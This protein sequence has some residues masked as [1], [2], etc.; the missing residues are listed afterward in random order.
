MIFILKRN[1]TRTFIYKTNPIRIFIP[2]RNSKMA[3]HEL[4]LNR[5]WA[6]ERRP[7][8]WLTEQ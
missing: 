5:L 2:K 6:Q 4:C 7:Y 3:I 1:P 8:P